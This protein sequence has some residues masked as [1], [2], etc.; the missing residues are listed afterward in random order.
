MTDSNIAYDVLVQN[1]LR[2]VVRQAL[3]IA[4]QGMPSGHHFYITFKTGYPGVDIPSH[5]KA[6]YPDEMSILLENEFWELD[7]AD[8]CFS[9]MLMFDT[10]AKTITVP[11]LAI[12]GFSDPY[13]NF[14]LKLEV[15]HIGQEIRK[16]TNAKAKPQKL[17]IQPVE[18]DTDT[19][20]EN[21]QGSKVIS[22]DHFRKK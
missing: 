11:F 14:G 5:L 21:D 16:K 1:G 12:S 17:K 6:N 4:R 9:V 10:T 22:L 15:E 19:A 20:I 13:A 18:S 3:D 7:V 8:D 2:T